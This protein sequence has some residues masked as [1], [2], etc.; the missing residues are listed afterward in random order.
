MAIRMLKPEIN[1]IPGVE[2][3]YI[4]GQVVVVDM[5]ELILKWLKSRKDKLGVTDTQLAKVVKENS[6]ETMLKEYLE[7][8]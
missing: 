3:M 7:T 2:G 5:D 8:H 1:W 4:K 6:P